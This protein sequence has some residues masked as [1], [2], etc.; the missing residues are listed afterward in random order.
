[1]K[2][3]CEIKEKLNEMGK[4]KSKS[5]NNEHAKAVLTFLKAMAE[6]HKVSI[7]DLNVHISCGTIHVQEY[8]PDRIQEFRGLESIDT[9]TFI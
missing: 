4:E 3:G 1:M 8:T 2:S 5:V 6:K 9:E 7:D